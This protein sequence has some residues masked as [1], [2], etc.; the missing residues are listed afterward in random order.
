MSDSSATAY[1]AGE[2]SAVVIGRDGTV[3][4]RQQWCDPFRIRVALDEAL[5]SRP[6]TAP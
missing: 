4:A 5:G 3:V 2:N 1:G 6:T